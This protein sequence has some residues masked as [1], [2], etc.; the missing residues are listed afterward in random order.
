M[1]FK[2]RIKPINSVWMEDAKL[3]NMILCQPEVRLWVEQEKETR[4]VIER[5]LL[6]IVSESQPVQQDLWRFPYAIG[7][8]TG[9]GQLLRL[10][11]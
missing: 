10:L 8:R 5:E 4:N 7:R 3:K 6:A 1:S 11:V 2:S 9:L